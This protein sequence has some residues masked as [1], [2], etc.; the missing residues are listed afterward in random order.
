MSKPYATRRQ[1]KMN[2]I[3]DK[4]VRIFKVQM[5][6]SVYFLFHR[7]KYSW[8][9]KNQ[10]FVFLFEEYFLKLSYFLSLHSSKNSSLPETKIVQSF[11]LKKRFQLMFFKNTY[12]DIL[13]FEIV[14]IYFTDTVHYF[15]S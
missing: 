6:S 1:I 11:R 7:L 8:I 15:Y 10:T 3:M 5:K 2:N 4:I 13:D 9:I 12:I 14:L